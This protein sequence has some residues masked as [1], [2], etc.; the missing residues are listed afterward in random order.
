VTPLVTP[1]EMRT[2]VREYR[3]E[4]HAGWQALE[5][6]LGATHDMVRTSGDDHFGAFRAVAR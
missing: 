1:L 5:A 4:Y 2:P 6:L 3:G